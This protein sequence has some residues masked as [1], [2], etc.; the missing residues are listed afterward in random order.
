MLQIGPFSRN[1][2]IYAYP[3]SC[4][5]GIALLEEHTSHLHSQCSPQLSQSLCSLLHLTRIKQVH[6]VTVGNSSSL[7]IEF[8][9]RRYILATNCKLWQNSCLASKTLPT[10][11][12]YMEPHLTLELSQPLTMTTT[13]LLTFTSY[14]THS[15]R[16]PANAHFTPFSHS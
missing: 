6:S 9:S 2:I 13:P 12:T 8:G 14:T 15:I 11:P 16:L 7:H 3:I 1:C 5:S 4:V 10:T